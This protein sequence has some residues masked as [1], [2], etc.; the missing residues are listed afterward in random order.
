MSANRLQHLRFAAVMVIFV[1]VVLPISHENAL[2]VLFA[3]WATWT[4]RMT[5]A[6]VHWFGMEAARVGTVLSHPDG[7]AYEIAARCTGIL[8]VAFLSVSIVAY[9]GTLRRKCLGLGIGI[10]LLLML[11]LTR[12]VHL[13]YLG[14]HHP[15]AFD[16]AHTIFW[17]GFL[18]VAIFGLWLAWARWSDAQSTS[19][20]YA[21]APRSR[22]PRAWVP[23][24][25]GTHLEHASF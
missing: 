12:L 18:I 3:P 10:L 23:Q 16:V 24:R 6:L 2:G 1:A 17:E 25:V 8:P 20:G 15:T 22:G 14:V 19:Q 13:F 9:P 11:N 5:L 4:A 7:F 21:L